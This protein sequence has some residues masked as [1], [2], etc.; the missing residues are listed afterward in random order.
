MNS[1]GAAVILAGGS[2]R[3]LGRD[4]AAVTIGGQTLLAR[5]VAQASRFCPQTAVSGRDPTPFL[6]RKVP[7]FPDA[8][9]NAGPLGGIVTA[10]ETLRTSCLVLS[11]DLP[12]MD[13]P[14]IAALIDAWRS[15]PAQ[16]VMTAYQQTGTGYIEALVAIYDPAAASL[17]RH[18]HAKGRL[19]LT[20]AI[21]PALRHHIPYDASQSH[22]FYNL[23]TPADLLG[24]RPRPQQ[25]RCPCTPA[26]G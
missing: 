20:K 6:T 8:I 9:A 12:H 16:A 11:C 17:L 14:T 7:W 5:M 23:N 26:G 4:K 10:L 3:R 18:A 21:P 25:G 13:A 1:P 24:L 22:P 15:R 19:S 2:S